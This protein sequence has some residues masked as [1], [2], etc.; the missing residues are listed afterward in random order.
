MKK[1]NIGGQAV[2]EGVMM[3]SPEGYGL[4]VRK[5]D[6]TI[7]KEYHKSKKVRKKGSFPT[8]PVVRGVVAF[9]DSMV[10][11]IRVTTR[12]AELLGEEFEEEPSKF[13]IWMAKKLGKSV[14]DIALGVAVVLALGLSIVLFVLLPSF[15]VGLF[16]KWLNGDFVVSLVE[17]VVRLT[18]FLLYL[19]IISR[20]KSIRRVFAYHG[21]EHKTIACYEADEEL[22]VENAMRKTRL[23]PRCGTNY[24]FLV[25]A[26]SI[27]FFACIP[28]EGLFPGV[29]EK[30]M[31]LPRMASRL[32][33]IPVVAGL[34]FEV[35]RGAAKSDNLLCRIVR[36]PGLALQR[37]TT[38]EPEPDMVEVAIVAFEMALNP[39][40][41]DAEIVEAATESAETAPETTEVKTTEPEVEPAA[42]TIEPEAETVEETND[43]EPAE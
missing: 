25:M 17:G 15:V 3:K 35:L 28:V 43:D 42:E 8:W 38:V 40:D 6:G 30:L 12:S 7:V 13:E 26:I 27:L 10:G 33:L 31:F 16:S 22:T 5:E 29:S 18:I 21:A 37:L 23:H 1:T 20:L 11:G 19:L 4:A 24:M 9:F 39:P 41:P 32:V 34:S 2:M 14:M 36:A